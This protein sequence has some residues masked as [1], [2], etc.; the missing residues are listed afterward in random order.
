MKQPVPANR[1]HRL[2]TPGPVV[3]VTATLRGRSDVTAVAWAMPLSGDPP[4]VGVALSPRTFIHELVRRSEEVTINV[5]PADLARQVHHCGTVSG[6]AEDKW[7]ATGLHATS[8]RQVEAP[9]IEECVAHLECGVVEVMPVGDHE[10]FVGQ[11]LGAWAE[12]DAFADGWQPEHELGRLLH[13]LG[14]PRYGVLAEVIDAT[15]RRAERED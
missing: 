12:A 5:P 15:K 14:G 9:W 3:L 4:L 13:H 8:A 7:A 10:L 11:V 2:L 1:I 6:A